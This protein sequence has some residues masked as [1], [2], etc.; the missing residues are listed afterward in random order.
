VPVY[1]YRC[2]GCGRVYEEWVGL[3]APVLEACPKCGHQGRERV[4][5]R[6]A[7]SV[8]AGAERDECMGPTRGCAGGGPCGCAS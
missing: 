2:G 7:I 5:S 4:P 1:E 8:A 3:S 6:F